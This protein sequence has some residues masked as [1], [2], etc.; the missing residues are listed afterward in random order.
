[1]K[2][3]VAFFLLACSSAIL[4]SCK[5][6]KTAECDTAT[7]CM[8]NQTSATI[9]YCWGC[10][11]FSETLAPGEKACRDVRGPINE[12]STVWVDFQ[13]ASGTRRVE[14]NKCYVEAVIQ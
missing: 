4:F 9:R 5:K 1:M 7:I 14:V 13:T 8:V 3:L 6:Q 10:N 12:S 2:K 11:I